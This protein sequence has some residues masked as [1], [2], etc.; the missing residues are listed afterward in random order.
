MKETETLRTLP[1]TERNVVYGSESSSYYEQQT[2]LHPNTLG[3]DQLLF[4]FQLQ[5]KTS[6]HISILFKWTN[7]LLL[8]LLIPL[9]APSRTA[10]FVGSPQEHR[11]LFATLQASRRAE[12]SCES[13]WK[14]AQRTL[15]CSVLF[16]F[17]T[18]F[19]SKTFFIFL[20]LKINTKNIP[21]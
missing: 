7:K 21:K 12:G 15:V 17:P 6:Q 5:L 11:Y 18:L 3:I 4:I 2:F 10:A 13:S 8:H 1:Q 14:V 16:F 20:M 9:I 19:L